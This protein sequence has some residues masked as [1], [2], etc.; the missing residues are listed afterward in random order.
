VPSF[1]CFGCFFA[2][3]QTM[4]SFRE[5][6]IFV[7]VYEERS[8]TAA[9][10]SNNAT[11]SG[12]SRYVRV[13]EEDLGVRLFLRS[14]KEVRPTPAA[15]L[16]YKRCIDILK[17]RESAL[18][19]VQPYQVGLEGRIVVG[20]VAAITRVA[21][22]PALLRFSDLHPNVSVRIVQGYSTDLTK[23]V[24]AET[25]EFA[26]A[27][28]AA[29]DSAFLETRPFLKCPEAL[30]TRRSDTNRIGPAGPRDLENANLVLPGGGSPRRGDLDRYFAMNHVEPNKILE[31]DSITGTLSIINKSDWYAII[32]PIGICDD[33]DFQN[34]SIRLLVDPALET[35]FAVIKIK[36]RNLSKAAD[37]F[38]HCLQ[39]EVLFLK[40][41]I[42]NRT[43]ISFSSADASS[44]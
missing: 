33:A 18:G 21:L 1:Q 24:H 41:L 6:D 29:A 15:D 30:V 42:G 38:L 35:N 31:I 28:I 34:L 39:E 2:E 7:S 13:L 32:S 20:L 36:K 26:I 17:A 23:Q 44:F 37:A 27:P 4:R 5:L 43:G 8:F 10:R 12:V 11:Q 22:G 9:A 14:K 3:A 40:E 19:S 25:V 16:F